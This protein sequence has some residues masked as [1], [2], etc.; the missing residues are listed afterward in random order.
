[1][2]NA[3]KQITGLAI[4]LSLVLMGCGGNSENSDKKSSAKASSGESGLTEFEQ[5]HGIGPV[6]DVITL[7]EIDME[8][9]EKGKELFKIKCSACHK[10]SERYIGPALGDVLERRSPSFVMNMIL[11][12]DEMVK[13][14]PVGKKLMAEFLSPMPNQNLEKEEARAIVEYLASV[15]KESTTN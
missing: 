9:V 14:H 8:M 1:M 15:E 12:P 11:N 13:K 6:K 2:K 10:T 7:G 5:E 3:I 4:L